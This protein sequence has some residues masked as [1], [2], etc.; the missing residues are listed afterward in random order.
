RRNIARALFIMMSY[1][2]TIFD[3]MIIAGPPSILAR[4]LI[5]TVGKVPVSWS[6]WFIAYLPCNLITIFVCWRVAL[7]LY[8]PEV[9]ELPG[10]KEVLKREL[11]Q[12]G[13]W[14][15][16]EKKCA[17][18]MFCAFSLWMT[19]AVHHIN[20]SI[21]GIGIGLAALLPGMGFL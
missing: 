6:L 13:P 12:L 14:S 8:P 4:G 16:Q 7:W 3:K 17:F 9:K 11:A 18:L 10:G 1:C 2:A 20:P 21:I 19:D 15:I 5:E